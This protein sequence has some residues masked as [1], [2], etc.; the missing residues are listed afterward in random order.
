MA[1]RLSSSCE[2][3]QSIDAGTIDYI[4][5]FHVERMPWH[6]QLCK[7]GF[8][9]VHRQRSLQVFE[10]KVQYYFNGILLRE[11]H[12]PI[13]IQ[14]GVSA[15]GIG[16]QSHYQY[17]LAFMFAVDEINKNPDLLH[18][19][20]LG[21][22]VYD[23]CNNVNKATESVLQILSGSR[24]L[25]P[26]YSSLDNDHLTGVIFHVPSGRSLPIVQILD[27]YKYTQINCGLSDPDLTNKQIYPS[28]FQTLPC[29]QTQ[30]LSIVKLLNHFMW[31]WVGVIATEDDV[32]EKHIQDLK[33]VVVL[34]DICIEYIIKLPSI[35]M[36]KN[37]PT[38]VTKS[39]DFERSTSKIIVLCGAFS[40]TLLLFMYKQ[41]T[42]H[43]KTLIIPPG[44]SM[45]QGFFSKH[46]LLKFNGCLV[47][48]PTTTH[49][50]ALSNFLEN[51]SIASRPKD[52]LLKYI[53]GLIFGCKISDPLLE[54]FFENHG[55]KLHVCNESLFLNQL[56]AT[57]YDTKR[58]GFTYQVYKAVYAMAHSIHEMLL[59]MP[60]NTNISNL[61]SQNHKN[62]IKFFLKRV[63]FQDPT[64]EDV[65]CNERREMSTIYHIVTYGNIENSEYSTITVGSFEASAKEGQKLVI[66]HDLIH[67]NYGEVPKSVCSADCPPGYRKQ[68]KEG[69]HRCCFDCVQCPE[70][71]ISNETDKGLCRKCPEDQWPNGYNQCAP[72]PSE[73]LS[74][75]KNPITLA[76]AFISA[77]LFGKTLII[78]GFFIKYRYTP[79]IKA[80]NRSLSFILL[81][82]IMLSFLDVFLFLD[83]PLQI[84]CML[85]QTFY[86]VLFSIA[87]S[88]ILAKTI[89]VY[90]AFK[91]TKPGSPWRKFIGAKIPIS[92]ILIC[93]SFQMLTSTVWLSVSPPFPENNTELYLDKIVI[94]CNEGSVVAFC[95]LLG[96]M[97]LLAAVTFFVAFLARNLPDSF[98]EA[99]YI[100]FSMLVF[101]SVWIAFIPAYMSV[102]GKNTVLVEIFAIIFSSSGILGC[103]FFPKCYIILVRQDLNSKSYLL[104]HKHHRGKIM[105]NRISISNL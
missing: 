52:I 82:S 75:L 84:T 21:Y 5:A 34:Y 73:Y 36:F 17:L 104:K 23:S 39:Q 77:F 3:S 80:N 42:S 99:K 15:D 6:R 28:Y 61:N 76:I 11:P 91:A 88:S 98:N 44:V 69:I 41:S 95:T 8:L 22:H 19:V 26:N 85:R 64:G 83:R 96:Y 66:S 16:H 38:F 57:V 78:M 40:P 51:V 47:F 37:S 67:W 45:A 101:C 4:I 10:E 30:Y 50:P 32:G 56:P 12:L 60:R 70:G 97:G 33:K 2:P 81:V 46:N 7:L 94:R 31:T 18:N 53:V 74:Y 48:V 25:I 29:D 93:S 86:G 90:M 79:V 14:L 92:L 68:K 35:D 65:F 72:K 62:I 63:H 89:M 13:D 54:T 9:T 71:E 27:L 59:Y 100:T 58:F 102:M 87:I 103:I 105:A 1:P 24:D 49:I 20:T 43:E 55:I